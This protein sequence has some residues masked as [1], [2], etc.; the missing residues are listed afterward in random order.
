VLKNKK[1]VNKF[2]TSALE[3]FMKRF[4]ISL[5]T[6]FLAFLLGVSCTNLVTLATSPLIQYSG[7]PLVFVPEIPD[8]PVSDPP[9]ISE[10]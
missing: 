9:E 7:R 10:S 6:A 4:F 3:S 2:H 8:I 5:P 1:D